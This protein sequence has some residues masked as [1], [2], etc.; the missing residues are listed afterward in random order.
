M[1][2]AYVSFLTD[3]TLWSRCIDFIIYN[4]FYGCYLRFFSGFYAPVMPRATF[5]LRVA[6]D[7]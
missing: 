4:A 5:S 6:K 1:K 2:V 3:L 7:D